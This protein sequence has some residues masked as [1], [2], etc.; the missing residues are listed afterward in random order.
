[1]DKA[2]MSYLGCTGSI[3]EAGHGR[4][5][6]KVLGLDAPVTYEG[7]SLEELEKAFQAAVEDYLDKLEEIETQDRD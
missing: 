2:T 6:G 7:Y 3:E 1:M 4:F 5:Y